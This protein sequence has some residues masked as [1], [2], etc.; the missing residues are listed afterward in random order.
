MHPWHHKPTAI[1]G[2]SDELGILSS[3]RH[4]SSSPTVARR[5][6]HEAPHY[7][8]SCIIVQ[9]YHTTQSFCSVPRSTSVSLYST[10]GETMHTVDSI[11]QHSRAFPA[12]FARQASTAS[13]T[14][15]KNHPSPIPSTSRASFILW[16]TCHPGLAIA[17]CKWGCFSGQGREHFTTALASFSEENMQC[18]LYTICRKPEYVGKAHLDAKTR[19][20]LVQFFQRRKTWSI[21]VYHICKIGTHM[22][23]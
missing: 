18:K 23:G 10:T 15:R 12:L 16:I 13:P 6:I 20:L 22:S 11:Q 8:W 9:H 17:I 14:V 7:S 4:S 2:H 5:T 1:V 3:D 19:Q 21:H